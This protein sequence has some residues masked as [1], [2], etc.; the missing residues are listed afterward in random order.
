MTQSGKMITCVKFLRKFQR[1]K[2]DIPLNCY[3]HT[4]RI[5]NNNVYKIK[6]INILRL[7]SSSTPKVKLNGVKNGV[8]V[9]NITAKKSEIRR[10][11]SL[12]KPE[13]W[14]LTGAITL[15]LISS[16]VTMAVPFCLGKIID[17]IY[18]EDTDKMKE[19]LKKISLLLLGVFIIGGICNFGR[20]YF[21]STSGHRIT[22]SLRKKAYSSILSQETGMFD[23]IS[24]GE[25]VGR[26]TGNYFFFQFVKI[27]K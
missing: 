26:L 23:K 27:F 19:N 24:T 13:K 2:I 8:A 10:L 3:Y 21:M 12:A 5:N 22:Q 20:I 15:L 7:N 11:F 14:K 17:V 16:T 6:N 9:K 18:T 1:I 25:L 4:L